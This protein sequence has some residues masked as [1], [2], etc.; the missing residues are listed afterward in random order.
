M[1]I[2]N[3]FISYLAIMGYSPKTIKTKELRINFF[4]IWLQHK[5]LKDINEIDIKRYYR[6]L[7]EQKADA[8]TTTINAYMTALDQFFTFTLEMQ[9]LQHHPF[10]NI[11]LLQN[12]KQGHRK[13]IN[14]E[15]IKKLYS[16]CE[17]LQEKA[18]MIVA[19]G[20]G[21]RAEE[22]YNLKTKDILLNKAMIFVASGKNNKRRYIPIKLNH[23]LIL[24]EYI[25]DYNLT[26]NTALFIYQNKKM[27]LYLIRK[28]FKELQEKIGLKSPL[29]TLHHLRHSIASHL[30]DSGVDVTLIQQ[31]LGHS[32]IETTQRYITLQNTNLDSGTDHPK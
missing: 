2:F 21:L 6:Y 19:Y 14:I 17:T 29:Y 23:L 25:Y 27:S 9:H 22:I 26:N 4:K 30:A 28:L 3:S 7:Q 11:I 5:D 10:T 13:P 24:R 32:N 8:K 18:L 20:A 1:D 12:D 15:T 31:F 16:A